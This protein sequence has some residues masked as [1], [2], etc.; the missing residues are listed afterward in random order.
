MQEEAVEVFSLM[1]NIYVQNYQGMSRIYL[2]IIETI[3][4]IN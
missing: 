4:N 2:K 3:P 1:H